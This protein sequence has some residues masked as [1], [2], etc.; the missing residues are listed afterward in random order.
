MM[1]LIVAIGS[2]LILAC[3]SFAT[4]NDIVEVRMVETA[5]PLQP[6]TKPA[7]AGAELPKDAKVLLSIEALADEAG[8]L[9]AKCTIGDDTTLILEGHLKATPDGKR[10]LKVKFSRQ[11]LSGVQQVSTNIKLAVGDQEV[12]GGLA[13]GKGSRLIVATVKPNTKVAGAKA[14]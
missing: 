1:K 12:I 8:D 6:T 2:S 9:H 14:G 13:A 3:G 11:D 4:A 10:Q 5:T 7:A